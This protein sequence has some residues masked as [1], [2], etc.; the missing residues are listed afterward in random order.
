MGSG[1]VRLKMFDIDSK[2]K[3]YIAKSRKKCYALGNWKNLQMKPYS[4]RDILT[5]ICKAANGSLKEMDNII[6]HLT[7]K[8][9]V[10]G[11]TQVYADKHVGDID[12][13][14]NQ[15]G[16]LELVGYKPDAPLPLKGQH[17]PQSGKAFRKSDGQ[18]S[19]TYQ[20]AEEKLYDLGQKVRELFPDGD[21]H[22]ISF[23]MQAIRK[24]ASERKI[25]TDK[26]VKG[27][28][29]GRYR[30]D[31]DMWRVVPNLKTES[32][33]SNKKEY[34][35]DKKGNIKETEEGK[36][37]PKYCPECGEKI[38]VRIEG[39]PI[40]ICKNDH[41]FG[42]VKFPT[43]ESK[44]KRIIV[45]N[46]SDLQRLQKISEECDREMEMTEQKFHSNIR[47]FISQLLQDPV[48]AQPSMLLKM[49]GLY[50]SVLLK[51]LL[52]NG[53]LVRDERI[54][55]VDENGE[56]KKATM[57]VKFKCRKKNFDR[58]I[59]KLYMRL[60]E[61]NLPQRTVPL[62]NEELNEDGEGGGAIAGAT[63]AASSGQFVQPFGGVQR[64]KMPTE[65]DETADTNSVGNYQYT[66]PFGGDKETLARKNGC[67]GSVSVNHV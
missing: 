59:Q 13:V 5:C 6:D 43:N 38:T 22:F 15:D 53:T 32:K 39:E 44:E 17:Q 4:V 58:R 66:V 1:K 18:I 26:V 57:M 14:K 31:A 46:E 11:R 37:V 60:F 65:I 49:H 36:K 7:A 50:R 33:E 41:Y 29:K 51:Y 45:I 3:E 30:I 56:P 63:S 2:I 19:K 20:N 61:K 67:N 21:N 25:H 62:R 12:I 64:R 55:D 24:Y 34:I 48:N 28:E 42:T 35:T 10:Y 47:N 54:S 40:Y 9:K 52:D 8:R 16:E 27:L 23:A